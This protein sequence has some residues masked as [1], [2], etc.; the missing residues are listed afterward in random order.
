MASFITKPKN[1]SPIFKYNPT[2]TA[3]FFSTKN[4]MSNYHSFNNQLMNHISYKNSNNMAQLIHSSQ[5]NVKHFSQN[6][7]T[8]QSTPPPTA[9]TT[10]SSLNN[11]QTEQVDDNLDE[12]ML[13]QS[14]R[15]FY[16]KN[17]IPL[18]QFRVRKY[19]A[20]Y[21]NT[22]A[23]AKANIAR[24][25][26]PKEFVDKLAY[27]IMRVCRVFVHMFFREKYTHHAVVLETVAAC[28]GL[29]GGALRHFKSLRRMTRDH[30]KIPALLE[31]AENERMHLLTWMHVCEPSVLERFLVMGAQFGFATFYTMLYVVSPKLS[32]RLVGYLEEEAFNAY[33]LFL[34]AIDK[35]NIPNTAAPEIAIKYWNLKPEAT[36]RDVVLCVRADEAM[37]RDYNHDLSNKLR[38]GMH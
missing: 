13:K 5:N 30:G 23:L 11:N 20:P 36:L 14:V 35:G 1:L 10:S 28:P 16:D 19:G 7:F 32:H 25:E 26:E 15:E 27:N 9:N 4:V 22:E 8:N 38:Y 24:H 34:D 21:T 3:S 29:I 6:A 2:N 31:E 37:H 17:H 12:K 18:A 33:T